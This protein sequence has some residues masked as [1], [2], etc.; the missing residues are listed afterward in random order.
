MPKRSKIDSDSRYHF[1]TFAV[2]KRVPIFRSHLIAKEFL[3]NL[4]FYFNRDNCKLHGFAI[5]PD[6]VHLL[7]ELNEKRKLSD[8]IRDIKKFFTYKVKNFLL[9]KTG[10]DANVFNRDDAFQFWERGF[11]EVTI[12]SER[13]FQVKLEYIHN[14][15][16]KAGLVEKAEDYYYSSARH[17]ILGTESVL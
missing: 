9:E 10:F 13:M 12:F 15:P 14:N 5:M 17:Y 6:H 16:V 11:D 3:S 2:Y 4:Q 7:L 8:F 1:V